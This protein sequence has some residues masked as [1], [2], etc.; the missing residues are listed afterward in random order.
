MILRGFFLG[1]GLFGFFVCLFVCFRDRVS[2]CSPGCSGT[3]FVEIHCLCLPSAGT[4]GVHHHCLAILGGLIT[5]SKFSFKKAPHT[6]M[7]LNPQ[8]PS[9]MPIPHSPPPKEHWETKPMEL[10]VKAVAMIEWQLKGTEG[11]SRL[12]LVLFQGLLSKF[13]R[14]DKYGEFIKLCSNNFYAF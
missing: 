13:R 6:L 4:K 2:L 8:E 9:P 12:L 3:H 5:L 14:W 11:A 10:E 1:G 7:Y